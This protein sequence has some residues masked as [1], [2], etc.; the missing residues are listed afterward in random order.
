DD[1][2]GEELAGSR[3]RRTVPR[4][5]PISPPVRVQVWDELVPEQ[6]RHGMLER[7]EGAWAEIEAC[8]A[9]G[10]HRARRGRAVER[11]RAAVRA[12]LVREPRPNEDERAR[13]EERDRQPPTAAPRVEA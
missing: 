12:L 2:R 6:G 9:P 1:V 7:A 10:Q 11:E 8:R 4:Q 13:D 5:R 3:R